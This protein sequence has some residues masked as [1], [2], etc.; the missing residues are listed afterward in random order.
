MVSCKTGFLW[1]LWVWSDSR[2]WLMAAQCHWTQ[3][4][5]K[6]QHAPLAHSWLMNQKKLQWMWFFLLHSTCNQIS[7][8]AYQLKAAGWAVNKTS[9]KRRD[10][11]RKEHTALGCLACIATAKLL[12]CIT[13][14]KLTGILNTI[15]KQELGHLLLRIF[16]YNVSEIKWVLMLKYI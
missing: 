6:R 5:Q 14:D 16:Y 12:S 9:H 13:Q 15:N 1:S 8:H 4:G 2:V 10:G 7:F 3:Q 11:E